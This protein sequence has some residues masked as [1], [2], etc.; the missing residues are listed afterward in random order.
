MIPAA[1]GTSPRITQ[2]SQALP[3]GGAAEHAAEHAEQDPRV[4]VVERPEGLRV[5]GR[6]PFEELSIGGGLVSAY[7]MRAAA[8][9]RPLG[10]WQ[11]QAAVTA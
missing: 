4:A 5:A 7:D 6:D 9:P 3:V 8:S 10:R 11:E 2:A 1:S